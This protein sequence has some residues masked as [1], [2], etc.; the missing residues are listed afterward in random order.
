[1]YEQGASRV[2]RDPY[3]H[4]AVRVNVFHHLVNDGQSNLGI[5]AKTDDSDS[6]RV[7]VIRKLSPWE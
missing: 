3:L 2:E 4:D 6:G 7:K 1:M 5:S